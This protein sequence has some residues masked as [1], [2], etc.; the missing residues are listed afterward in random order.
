MRASGD[1]PAQVAAV[2]RGLGVGAIRSTE[3]IKHGLTNRSWL[4]TTDAD[5]VVVRI[6]RQTEADLLIDRHSEAAVLQRLPRNRHSPSSVSSWRDTASAARSRR[7][8]ER[9]SHKSSFRGS[10]CWR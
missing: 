8:S 10:S 5:R 1:V 4:V 2:V 6:S 9:H 7:C 3:P